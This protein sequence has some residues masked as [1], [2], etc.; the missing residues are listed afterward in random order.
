MY[1]VV[2][3]KKPDDTWLKMKAVWDACT[4]AKINIP[5]QVVAFFNHNPPNDN[6]VEIRLDN[7]PSIVT[8]KVS[9]KES[10]VILDI[11]ELMLHWDL[12]TISEIHFYFDDRG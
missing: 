1:M 9:G 10:V 2:G 7:F 5:D 3:V 6:G 4:A 11:K 12:R 8:G